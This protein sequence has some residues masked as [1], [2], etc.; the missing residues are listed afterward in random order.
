MEGEGEGKERKMTPA[1][2]VSV[3]A[4]GA[5]RGV[6]TEMVSEEEELRGQALFPR[7]C[8]GWSFGLDGSLVELSNGKRNRVVFASGHFVVFYDKDGH[9]QKVKQGHGNDVSCMCTSADRKWVATADRGEEAKVLVWL[10]ETEVAA[11]AL[12]NPHPYGVAAMDMSADGR[13]LVTVS[14]PRAVKQDG[15]IRD[16]EAAQ[17]V[18]VWDWGNG[19]AHPIAE[20]EV[21][22]PDAQTC[23]KFN[24]DNASQ[25]VTS[26][27]SRTCFWE[28]A[29]K[30]VEVAAAPA[31]DEAASEAGVEDENDAPREG[32]LVGG[33]T[34]H[35][36]VVVASDFKQSIGAYSC[37]A[38]I[39]G[40]TKAVTATED[41]DLIV[42]EDITTSVKGA[43]GRSLA[44]S[45]APA[46]A[47]TRKGATKIIRLHE[48]RITAVQ[49]IDRYIATA[50]T[51]GC[52]RFYD[53]RFRIAAWF[54]DM[55]AGPITSLSFGLYPSADERPRRAP[56]SGGDAAN[57]EEEVF[58]VPHFTVS[59]STAKIV[60]LSADLFEKANPA[61]RAGR[62]LLEGI[63][64]GVTSM[65]CDT[66]TTLAVAV[67]PGSTLY[68]LD[69][70]SK[71]LAGAL[72]V[73]RPTGPHG[74]TAVQFSPSGSSF[75][76][77]YSNGLLC[78]HRL[79]SMEEELGFKF[80]EECVTH[81]AFSED[82]TM[83]A[84]ADAGLVVALLRLGTTKTGG[85]KWEFVGKHRSHTDAIAAISFSGSQRGAGNEYL[86]SIGE[87]RRIVSYNVWESSVEKGLL[88]VGEP[89]LSTRGLAK[90]T[91]MTFSPSTG[92]L[93][94]A[95]NEHKIRVLEKETH[96][97]VSLVQAPVFGGPISQMQCF[98]EAATGHEYLAF[99]LFERAV[100][101]VRL[102]L[103][104]DPAGSVGIVAHAGE[105]ANFALTRDGAS[106]LTAGSNGIINLWGIDC[107][108]VED[109]VHD[110]G[111]LGAERYSRLV[112]DELS[113]G[114]PSTAEALISDI[115]DYF[116]YAEIASR[117]NSKEERKLDFCIPLSEVPSVMRA[118]GFYPS[119]G[120]IKAMQ[121]EVERSAGDSG[122]EII[123]VNL[124]RFLQLFFNYRPVAD[125]ELAAIEKTFKVMAGGG[126]HG[127]SSVMG[128]ASAG[129]EPSLSVDEL[130]DLLLSAGE[131]M[132]KPELEQCLQA[133][134]GA[135]TLHE[136]LGSHG[137]H[138]KV[139]AAEFAD[140]IL[141]LQQ[142]A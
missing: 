100:G 136:A 53:K 34:C 108:P 14:A 83:C 55:H 43:A 131:L 106:M 94:L 68:L 82:G 30:V 31:S 46:E 9:E 45:G 52:V 137:R 124:E 12:T 61:A 129:T 121:R 142:D 4:A 37:S 91:A 13:Y 60:S 127:S 80:T 89:V 119:E 62:L 66:H 138:A 6:V 86:C 27:T 65:S 99:S 16:G 58:H 21:P 47:V 56:D 96:E 125:L 11:T 78:F 38:F 36:P 133:L 72:A 8:F 123:Y 122:G 26:G 1:P 134:C 25:I 67:G 126:L 50:S 29:G 35:V 110:S 90:P 115:Q 120:D 113:G 7:W 63:P 116:Y 87:D 112:A 48:G 76:V 44:Q 28:W 40:T 111:R 59:T 19:S 51:D 81:I 49:V 73:E 140:R 20:A 95:N 39:A 107:T 64:D 69:V 98:E 101:L 77:G 2:G 114:D 139:T 18:A 75:A 103:D 24:P 54:E 104:G 15:E 97:H 57:G 105:I 3:A 23:V 17:T 135:S 141:G 132:S 5:V 88:L 33:L 79:P 10:A 109:A 118:I 41:G 128:R 92:A 84:V 130:E 85:E 117:V 70:A 71:R 42:W 74:A 93:I 102:P 22:V 32:A